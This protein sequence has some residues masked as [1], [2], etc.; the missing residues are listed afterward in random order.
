VF[1]TDIYDVSRKSPD[2]P[3]SQAFAQSGEE[4]E[5]TWTE[6]T[7]WFNCDRWKIYESIRPVFPLYE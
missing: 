6:R 3:C 2:V 7:V 5:G 1:G 4:E